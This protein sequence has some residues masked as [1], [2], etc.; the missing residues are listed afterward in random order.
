MS[1]FARSET[2]N[3]VPLRL[4]R[5]ESAA[6]LELLPRH[7]EPLALKLPERQANFL[8]FVWFLIAKNIFLV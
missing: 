1:G 3:L 7:S 5:S 8:D 4:E 6:L 2:A